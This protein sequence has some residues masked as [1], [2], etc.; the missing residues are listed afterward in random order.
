[1]RRLWLAALLG[2]LGLVAC[3]RGPALK[4][5]TESVVADLST[6]AV[7]THDVEFYSASLKRRMTYRVLLPAGYETHPELSYPLLV[8]LHGRN[9]THQREWQANSNLTQL[10]QGTELIAVLPEG[11]DSYYTNAAQKPED[12]YEDYIVQDLMM[13][14]RSFYRIRSDRAAHGIGGISMGGWGALNLG[15]RHPDVFAF[16]ASLSAPLDITSQSFS[17]RRP[18]NARYLRKIFGQEGSRQRAAYDIY[19]L[20][21][22]RAADLHDTYFFLTCGTEEG[23]LDPNRRMARAMQDSALN[24]KYSEV[25]G[26]HNWNNWNQVLP[27]MIAAAREKLGAPMTNPASPGAPKAN[28]PGFTTPPAPAKPDSVIPNPKPHPR[29]SDRAHPP[30]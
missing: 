14:V 28:L 24:Y 17:W 16:V 23:L 1:M 8:L 9:Y 3:N 22:A 27:Q 7:S 29:A 30:S 4:Q 10:L 18:F 20:D 12:R 6:A 25:P 19:K 15:M 26:A 21:K 11:D 5:R 2:L 13:D